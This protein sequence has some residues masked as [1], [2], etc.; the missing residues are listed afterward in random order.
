HD[1]RAEQVAVLGS[2]AAR[3]LGITTLA[4][5]PAI[6]IDGIPFTVL[7]ILDDVARNTDT[8]FNVL[9][10]RHTAQTLWG[11]PDP[12]DRAQMLVQTRVGAAQVVA[13]QIPLA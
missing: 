5:R 12:S 10:P 8:L 7:G 3:R 2:A 9:V 4:V 11:P 13:R 6:F 1:S